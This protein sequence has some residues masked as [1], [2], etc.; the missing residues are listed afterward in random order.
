MS[1]RTMSPSSFLAARW[2]SVP[3]IMPAPIRAIFL[4]GAVLADVEE[5][6]VEDKGR[7]SVGFLG[8]RP[9]PGRT[10]GSVRASSR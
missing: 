9:P 2:A 8:V 1:N 3:P 6:V 10:A 7:V 5:G 4:R